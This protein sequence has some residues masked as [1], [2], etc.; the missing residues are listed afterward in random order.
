MK[1]RV[2]LAVAL[3]VLTAAAVFAQQ[4]MMDDSGQ[5]ILREGSVVTNEGAKVE[6][7][8]ITAYKGTSPR[9]SIGNM[10]AVNGLIVNVIG[11]GDGAFKSSDITSFNS[12]MII[13][14]IGKNAFEGCAKLTTV[15]LGQNVETVGDFAFLNC[16]NLESV[17]ISG[18]LITI[19]EQAFRLCKKLTS[20][21]LPNTLKTM[22]NSAFWD[23]GLTSVTI[24][25]S[26][27]RIN[28]GAFQVCAN[29]TS[30][31]I[32]KGVTNIDRVAFQSCPKLTSVTF[33]GTIPISGFD[34]TAFGSGN[35]SVGDIR[36]KFYAANASGGT[37]GRYMRASGTATAW[38]KQ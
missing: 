24:P 32:G 38:A 20:I 23:A 15:T 22:G 30:V 3:I 21:N 2:F 18:N 28:P 14:T 27:T 1:S 17:T 25:D 34:A 9:V 26:L 13:F 5:F 37:P 10:V 16:A 11:I 35:T 8:I 31:I 29:L 4:M 19:G 33:N 12:G 7:V 36:D 6:G